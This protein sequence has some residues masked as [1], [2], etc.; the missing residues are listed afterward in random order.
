MKTDKEKE[1]RLFRRIL[2]SYNDFKQ[3]TDISSHILE[4]KLHYDYPKRDQHILQALNCAMIVA[5]ARP[6]SGNRGSKAMLRAL[7]ERFLDGFTSEERQLHKVVLDD[8]NQLLAHSDDSAWHLRLGVMRS[9]EHNPMLVPIHHDVRAPLDEKPTRMFNVMSL[10]L[11]DAAFAERRI[12]EKEL[13]DLLPTLSSQDGRV[14][15]DEQAMRYGG[16]I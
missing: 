11:M 3:A 12:L 14:T 13:V 9:S 4:A 1:I 6:F 16:W 15:G 5:Y 2:V 7:P 8:R 10:K